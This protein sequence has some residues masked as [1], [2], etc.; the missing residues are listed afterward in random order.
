MS[1]S[2]LIILIAGWPLDINILEARPLIF[3]ILSVILKFYALK[4]S[5]NWMD[6][7]KCTFYYLIL[8]AKVTLAGREKCVQELSSCFVNFFS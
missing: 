8:K 5:I 6:I 3:D 1:T 2:F 7:F 4:L